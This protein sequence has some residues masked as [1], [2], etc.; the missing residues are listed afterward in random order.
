MPKKTHKIDAFEGGLNNN[1]DPRDVED[2][3]FS[4]ISGLD[5][6]NKWRL[7]MSGN[8]HSVYEERNTYGVKVSAHE[9]TDNLTNCIIN[10]LKSGLKR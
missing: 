1:A 7:R 10:G 6:S 3:Q 4:E 5:V 8:M 2:N 9:D